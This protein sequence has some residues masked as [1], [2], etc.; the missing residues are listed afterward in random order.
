M[1]YRKTGNY[2]VRAGVLAAVVALCG[3]GTML[4]SCA[5]DGNSAHGGRFTNG[6]ALFVATDR[7]ENGAGN[8]L[9]AMLRMAVEGS[10]I[11]PRLVVLGGDY[12]GSG[13]GANPEFPI[14]DL[15]NEIDSIL[16]P[17]Y[18]EVVITYGSHD[19]NC[20]DGYSA[21][22]SGP[23]CQDGYYVYGVSYAQMIYATDDAVREALALYQERQKEGM[24]GRPMPGEDADRDMPPPMG[25]AKPYNG[26]DIADRYGLSAESATASFTAWVRSLTDNRPIVVMSHVP[27]HANRQDNLGAT[28]WYEAL[29][30]AAV[31]HDII[32][33]WGHNHTIEEG[34][35]SEQQEPEDAAAQDDGMDAQDAPP[36]MP[37]GGI[38][39]LNDRYC[40][41]LTPGEN[42]TLQGT[43]DSLT[44]ERQLSF[45]YANA[46]YLK[47][48]QASVITFTSHDP[49]GL[50]DAMT[51]RRFVLSP[52]SAETTFGFTNLPNPYTL[53]LKCRMKK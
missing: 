52:D 44:V 24:G 28:A 25:G 17:P 32:F 26:L 31:S 46:G 42:I 27:M 20:T 37:K 14:S 1:E 11:K 50:Y 7:H 48:G 34:A 13:G 4:T 9:A 29:S 10:D 8:N 15:Y 38:S 39:N 23:R 22:F 6:T 21:F 40:Y 41:L 33:L 12:V 51:I 43:A 5:E 19:E 16:A 3:F 47:M 36:P 49:S 18:R 30:E 45:T 35:L 2:Y 53:P